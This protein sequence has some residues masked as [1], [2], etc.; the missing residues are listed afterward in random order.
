[1]RGYRSISP[2]YFAAFVIGAA[3]LCIVLPVVLT[4]GR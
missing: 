4:A 2:V 1:M 3:L